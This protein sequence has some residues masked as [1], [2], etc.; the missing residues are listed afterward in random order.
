MIYQNYCSNSSWWR[1][2]CTYVVIFFIIFIQTGCSKKSAS[3]NESKD[4][5]VI[6]IEGDIDSFNPLFAQDA[7]AGEINDLFFPGLTGSRFDTST[8]T[9][10]YHPLLAKAWE[11]ENHNKDIR[12]HLRTDARWSDGASVTSRDVQ[13]SYELYGDTAV[14]SIRQTSVEGLRKISN[15][16]DIK[17]AVEVIDDSTVVFHFERPYPGQM[18]DA[19]LPILPAHIFEK[20]PR[21]TLREDSVNWR[22]LSSGPFLL[23]SYKPMQE[24]ILAPNPLSVLPHPARLSQLIYRVIPDY[25]SRLLQLKKGDVDILPYI[26]A[27]D[28]VGFS[29]DNSNIGIHSLG[30]R[31]YDAINWNNIDPESFAK[32][33]GKTIKPHPLFGSPNVRKALTMA[34]NRKEIVETYLHSFGREAFSPISPIFRWAYND[35]LH[36]FPFDPSAAATLMAKEG[37]NDSDGD[38]VLDKKARKFSFT[39]KVP[40]G[41]QLRATIAQVVQNRLKA[42]KIEVNIEQVERAVFWDDVFGKNFDACIAGFSVPLQMQLDEMWGSDLP[43]AVLNI[44]SFRHKRVD[45]ILVGAKRIT[46]DVE[47]AN[48]WKEFQ[49]IIQNEQPCTFLYWMNDLVAVNKRIKG[50]GIGI[51]GIAYHAGEWHVEEVLSSGSTQQ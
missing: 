45:E 42:H 13:L 44:P 26:N 16:L 2:N 21:Q 32:S 1:K 35:T 34:I 38:G 41:N 15:K 50:T 29:K 19:G 28:A 40:A 51:L 49:V 18:F 47:H 11:F 39:L 7:T 14:A 23:K 43:R 6:A 24:I 36:P 25:Q 4:Y 9:L 48:A 22:P 10:D 8:G 27:E 37:W 31:F 12:F 30:E 46:K 3:N 5:V 17:K 20:I 33:G